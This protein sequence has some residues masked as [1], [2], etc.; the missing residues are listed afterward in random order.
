MAPRPEDSTMPGSKVIAAATLESPSSSVNLWSRTAAAGSSTAPNAIDP[1]T[2]SMESA[3]IV[4]LQEELKKQVADLKKELAQCRKREN[5]ILAVFATNYNKEKDLAQREISL[6]A[7][8]MELKKL[9]EWEKR[10]NAILAVFAVNHQKESELT[11]RESELTQRDSELTQRDN[12]ITQRDNS[13]T[14]RDNE[15][16]QRDSELTQRERAVE[17]IE[18]EQ[19]TEN[20]RLEWE[21][22]WIHQLVM[23]RKNI[24]AV[25][26]QAHLRKMTAQRL[27][28][29]GRALENFQVNPDLRIDTSSLPDI[30]MDDLA[31]KLLRVHDC[32]RGWLDCNRAIDHEMALHE[33]R[34]TEEEVAYLTDYHDYRNPFNAGSMA[35]INFTWSALC[36]SHD[37]PE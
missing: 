8:E 12:E 19:E 13:P 14:Q 29:M 24:T 33:G 1:I 5:A 3:T 35:G 36:H 28:H 30:D 27:L 31:V 34:I 17:E 18:D 7:K 32:Y 9:A 11:Q 10:E 20:E 23:S 22:A 15:L 25:P 26:K 37:K 21:G 6:L 4:D 16:I 2:E